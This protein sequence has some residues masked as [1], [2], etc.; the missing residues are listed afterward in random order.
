MV[1]KIW[2][3][4]CRSADGLAALLV[5]E[6][7]MFKLYVNEI[8]LFAE[9]YFPFSTRLRKK[10]LSNFS[11]VTCS[12]SVAICSLK[13]IAIKSLN[14]CQSSA[15]WMVIGLLFPAGLLSLVGNV[16]KLLLQFG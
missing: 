9:G 10:S 1:L 4:S 14:F 8:Y 16:P 13:G 15:A 2:L 5:N 12:L 3:V 6:S 7:F 11:S